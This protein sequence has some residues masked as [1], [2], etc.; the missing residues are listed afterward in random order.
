MS[1]STKKGGKKQQ[2]KQGNLLYH[3]FHL[4]PSF[5][6]LDL[7]N[8]DALLKEVDLASNKVN[9]KKDAGKK[10]KGECLFCF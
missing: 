7:D 1:A 6:D 5:L 8:L 4:I 3:Y 10:A 2:T 9:A